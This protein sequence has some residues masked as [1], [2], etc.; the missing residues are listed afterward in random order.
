MA[1]PFRLWEKKRGERRT[2]SELLGNVGEALF[3]TVLFVLGAVSLTALL[4]THL[5]N[6]DGGTYRP[7]FGFWLMVLVLG[8]FVLL[9]GGG[10]LWTVFRVSVSAERRSVLARRAARLDLR[11]DTVPSPTAHPTIP[12]HDN[13]TN[14]PGVR[15]RYRLPVVQSPAWRLMMATVYCLIWNGSAAVLLVLTVRS[16]LTAHPQWFLTLFTIPFLGIG[17]WSILDL[18]RQL[19]IHTGIGPTNLEVSEHPLRPGGDYRVC[20]SQAGRLW[21]K[22]LTLNLVCEEAAMYR[23][24]TDIRQETKTVFDRQIFR[25]TD[26]PIEPGMPFEHQCVLHI[27][28]EAMHSFQSEHNAVNWRLVV[29]GEAESWPPY[30][31][32]FPIIVY[33]THDGLETGPGTAD[34]APHP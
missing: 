30:E 11:G 17:V 31:R 9:G 27:P 19:V 5:T 6:P 22:T 25:Q 14:S 10:A 24:G 15:L 20:L 33:P 32:C 12:S 2:G 23:Q 28:P 3:S 4:T 21:L 7:G 18:V 34:L 8:S 13:L 26:F 1:R 29:R 16:H